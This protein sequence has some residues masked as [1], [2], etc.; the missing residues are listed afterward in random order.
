MLVQPWALQRTLIIATYHCYSVTSD[1]G[2]CS[3][4]C[5]AC[6]LRVRC[7][8]IWNC[9]QVT[10]V[11]V[12]TCVLHVFCVFDVEG[13]ETAS[14]CESFVWDIAIGDW[15]MG[16]RVLHGI[17]LHQFVLHFDEWLTR[18]CYGNWLAASC[19]HMLLLF[20]LISFFAAKKLFTISCF[21]HGAHQNTMELCV[22][23]VAL[24]R[25]A[26][27][28]FWSS[29]SSSKRGC[30]LLSLRWQFWHRHPLPLFFCAAVIVTLLQSGRWWYDR[31]QTRQRIVRYW[32]RWVERWSE[33]AWHTVLGSAGSIL[34]EQNKWC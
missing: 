17:P 26:G 27:G 33:H 1:C 9:I 14:C 22:P 8:G 6:F 21:A 13:F 7:W 16:W 10:V 19:L 5:F 2:E 15:P 30:L 11:S 18:T 4:L 3:D 29:S 31:P 28:R 25:C 20:G 12:A 23:S 24:N 32:P 34:F